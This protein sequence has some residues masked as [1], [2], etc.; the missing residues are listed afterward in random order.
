LNDVGYVPHACTFFLFPVSRPLSARSPSA[1]AQQPAT[2]TAG[3]CCSIGGARCW[4]VR[5]V[6]GIQYGILL[7]HA[8]PRDHRPTPLRNVAATHASSR[9]DGSTA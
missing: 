3:C 9:I 8:I 4:P 2:P 1:T 6:C 5:L 7:G